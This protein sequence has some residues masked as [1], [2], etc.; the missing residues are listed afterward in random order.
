MQKVKEA[1]RIAFVGA[2]SHASESLYPNIPMIPEF[3]LVAVCDLIEERARLRAKKYGAPHYFSKVEVML[4]KVRLDGVCICGPPQMHYEVGLKVL[5]RGIP[6]WVE[7]PPAPDLAK[8]KELAELAK[9]RNT[10]GMVGF[11]KRFAPAN[12]VAK[13]FIKRLY[14]HASR[15]SLK[16]F[17]HKRDRSIRGIKDRL[18][19]MLKILDEYNYYI[20]T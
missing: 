10:F 12:L 1:A 20:I 4:N 3:D 15:P 5:E 9:K 13:E 18:P 6:V 11:M 8:T 16:D 17:E 7:K 14:T 2:G 19:S